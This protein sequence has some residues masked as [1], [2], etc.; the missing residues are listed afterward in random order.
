MFANG[1]VAGDLHGEAGGSGLL[2]DFAHG[3][4]EERGNLKALGFD[5]RDRF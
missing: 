1:A 2:N 4:A 3:E 5:Y